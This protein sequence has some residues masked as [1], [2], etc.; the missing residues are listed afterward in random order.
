MKY[1]M[2]NTEQENHAGLHFEGKVTYD[3]ILCGFDT[4]EPTKTSW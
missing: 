2:M 4:Q 3:G 1:L